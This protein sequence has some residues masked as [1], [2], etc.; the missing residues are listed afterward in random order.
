MLRDSIQ[1]SDKSSPANTGRCANAG[2]ML[3]HSR[4]QWANMKPALGQRLV[5]AG[6]W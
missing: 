4:R 5:S 3:V 2:F 1:A 6:L